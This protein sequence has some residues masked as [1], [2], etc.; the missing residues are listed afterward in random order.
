MNSD[1]SIFPMCVLTFNAKEGKLWVVSP[2]NPP[3]LF[4]KGREFTLVMVK[5]KGQGYNRHV[6]KHLVNAIEGKL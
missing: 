3:H 5:V 1:L 2:P 6:H 4:L